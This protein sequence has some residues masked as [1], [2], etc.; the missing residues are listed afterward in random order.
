LHP[1]F[2]VWT[3]DNSPHEG[4]FS[5]KEKITYTLNETSRMIMETFSDNGI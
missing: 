5:T 1:D 4:D 3:G 2:I